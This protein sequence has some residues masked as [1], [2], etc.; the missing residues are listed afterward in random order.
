MAACD[1]RTLFGLC[2]DSS[3]VDRLGAASQ[4]PCGRKESI[5]DIHRI[6]GAPD[7]KH[8]QAYTF[9][10]SPPN[11]KKGKVDKIHVKS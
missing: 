7:Q 5:Q 11:P 6:G 3:R 1:V 10:V 4:T 2:I 8:T 9:D